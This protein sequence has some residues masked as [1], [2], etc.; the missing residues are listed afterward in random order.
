M[1]MLLPVLWTTILF[2][3][4]A[5][6]TDQMPIEPPVSPSPDAPVAG[7]SAEPT[8]PSAQP[9]SSPKSGDDRLVRGRAYV[10]SVD[11]LVRESFP[12]Q[13]SLIIRGSL[14]TPCHQLR[15]FIQPP[16]AENRIRVEVYSV[17]DPDMV[18]IQVLANFEVSLNLGS[19]PPGHYSVWVDGKKVGEF[20]S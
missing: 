9:P 18:C 11:M 12:P 7:P 15:T 1:K 16:D 10:D 19:F 17:V 6:S 14:P 3:T 2:L 8:W 13:V 20:D 4:V 5:C